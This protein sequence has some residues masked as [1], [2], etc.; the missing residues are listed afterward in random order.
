[1]PLGT[2]PRPVI[3]DP[4]HESAAFRFP[5]GMKHNLVWY[6]FRQ[7][8]PADP[9]HLFE[10][11]AREFGTIAHYKI[12]PSHIVFVNDPALI[13][14]VLVVQHDNF[15]KERT[16]RRT[17]MLLGEGM[18]TA[19]GAKHRAER[20]AAQPAFYRERLQSYAHAIVEETLATTTSWQDGSALDISQQMM[21]LTLR[22]V[23]R[24]LFSTDL[25]HE[26]KELAGAINDI[27]GIYN[28]L[29][30]LPAIELLIHMRAPL[31]SR[32]PRARARLD[33]VIY[34]IIDDRLRDPNPPGDL[35]TMMIQS[36]AQPLDREDI[37]DQVITIFL[38][39]YET[40]ANALTWALDL[41]SQNPDA[42]HR[43]H[44]EVTRVLGQRP[45]AYSD[46]ASLAYT[47]QVFAE[48]MRLYP[49]AW[50][51][52]R[53]AIRDFDLGP[54]RLPAGT[55]V[56]ISQFITHRDPRY[57]EDPLAFRPERFASANHRHR[58]IYF[59]FGAGPRQCIG[60]RFAWMEG[61]LILATVAQR[62]KLSLVPGHRVAVQPLITLRPRYGMQMTLHQ[63]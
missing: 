16:Q 12:G 33:N 11:L 55:T 32:F 24:T 44:E 48:A 21:E 17:R 3:A 30:G 45:P 53:Q 36:A 28:Y 47:E 35:L 7:F 29:V 38:A 46:V 51:M 15:V 23:A 52:G 62:W 54:Y 13:R 22:I 31:V 14:E 59:P 39:G 50:A 5:P 63:R 57:W 20:R 61:V 42:D 2:E 18:I 34:R 9:I 8:R 58:M 1:M 49:P 27:M 19:E 37:R 25:R 40:V 56:L 6:A 41:L 26:A 10:H 43:L 4:V 60:E